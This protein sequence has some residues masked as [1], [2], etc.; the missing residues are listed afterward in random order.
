MDLFTWKSTKYLLI[1][2]YYSR[3]IEVAKLPTES[4]N[5]TI[6]VL[7]SIFARHDIPQ[8]VRSDN[9]PQFSSSV[10]KQ[11]SVKNTTLLMLLIALDTLPVMVK[12]NKL[13]VL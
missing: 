5:D 10:F 3:Y 6:N 12:L 7:K 2:D 4:S 11:F 9:G 8:E 1:I 13:Y